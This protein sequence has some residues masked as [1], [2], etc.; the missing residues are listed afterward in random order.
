MGTNYHAQLLQRLDAINSIGDNQNIFAQQLA[1]QQAQQRAAQ[2]SYSSTSYVGGGGGGGTSNTTGY[3]P[4]SGAKG[5]TFENF[6]HA[7]SG[8]ES[9]GNYKARNPDSGALGKYQIMPGNVGPW[10]RQI[11]GYSITPQQFY[12]SPKY[13]EQIAQGM[14]RQYYNQYGPGGAAVAWYAGPGTASKWMKNRN[15]GYYNSPQGKYSSINAYA[16]G[17]MRAMGIA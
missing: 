8:R 4:A 5:N 11:L 10:S 15:N 9:G 2:S 16:L 12:A 7:I 13:Q 1:A 3:V 17:I 14:L 6:L